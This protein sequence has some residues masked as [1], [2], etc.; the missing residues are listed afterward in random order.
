MAE[1]VPAPASGPGPRWLDEAERQTWLSWVFASRLLWEELERDLQE[2]AGYPFGYYEILMLL[3][4]T[5]G[6]ARRM[7]DLADATQS[8]RSRL[9]HAIDRLEQRGWVRRE[10][11]PNDRRGSLAV[12]T[13]EGMA[14]L[15]HAAPGHVESVRRHLFDVL[16]P[17]QLRE[18]R[19]ISDALLDHLLPAVVARGDRRPQMI[20][21]ARRLMGAGE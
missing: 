7:S 4:E 20:E 9:T 6:R 19:E 11:C 3:S 13:D 1:P 2:E 14:A 18:L 10:T 8:S 5:P 15:E 17:E 16:T 12:L 21:E